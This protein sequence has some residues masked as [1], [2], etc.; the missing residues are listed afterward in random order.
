MLNDF[1]ILTLCMKTNYI[2]WLRAKKFSLFSI[3][4]KF[5]ICIFWFVRSNRLVLPIKCIL[6]YQIIFFTYLLVTEGGCSCPKYLDY[7]FILHS[8]P[9]ITVFMKFL[10]FILDLLKKPYKKLWNL[11]KSSSR[12]NLMFLVVKM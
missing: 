2:S 6:V 10:S 11:S 9:L 12:Y 4:P 8:T 7:D 5:H 3:W 1:V